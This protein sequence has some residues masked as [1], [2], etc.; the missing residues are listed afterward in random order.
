MKTGWQVVG[1]VYE[2]N[3]LPNEWGY[4][5]FREQ[6]AKVWRIL[7]SPVRTVMQT[8]VAEIDG[9]THFGENDGRMKT[10][11]QK[12]DVSGMPRC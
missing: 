7:V 4:Y 9:N 6:L 10:G 12:I 8:D 11:W 2:S 1:A 5:G 3:E